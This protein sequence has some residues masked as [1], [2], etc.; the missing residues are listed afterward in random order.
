[1]M[2]KNKKN[3][4]EILGDGSNNQRS[5]NVPIWE[6]LGFKSYA[7]YIETT[8]AQESVSANGEFL[9]KDKTPL[10][11]TIEVCESMKMA[12]PPHPSELLEEIMIGHDMEDVA[13]GMGI[14]IDELQ[15]L[16]KGDMVFSE[17]IALRISK[18]FRTS[19]EMWL[20]LQKQYDEWND[21]LNTE[22]KK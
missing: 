1:M 21:P 11:D 13:V 12:N 9:E 19:Q 16:L 22:N 3:K 5:F 4:V 8:A 6:K 20:R 2:L 14:E 18:Y 15:I 10:E 17:E 7:A